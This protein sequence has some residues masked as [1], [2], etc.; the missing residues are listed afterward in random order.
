MP[1]QAAES[2]IFALK[3]GSKDQRN[4]FLTGLR[5]ILAD[6]HISTPSASMLM[7]VEADVSTKTK[8]SNPMVAKRMSLK[9]AAE[10]KE[11]EDQEGTFGAVDATAALTTKE[12]GETKAQLAAERVAYERMM[13]QMLVLAND[14]N[15]REEQ[16]AALKK[17]EESYEQ[18]IVD[19][20]NMFKQDAMVRMQ[21]GRRLEQVLMDKEEAVE[22][23]EN[24]REQL[25]ALKAAFAE[26]G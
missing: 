23:L 19:R 1:T 25:E 26:G 17:K 18:T 14:L 2:R 6:V 13:I 4:V 10:R 3:F 9:V 24:M 20:D 7:N 16:I 21:L 15:D 12:L 8:N 22:Q 11:A 5:T